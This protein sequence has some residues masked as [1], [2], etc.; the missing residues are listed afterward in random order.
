MYVKPVNE[1]TKDEVFTLGI[2]DTES[3]DIGGIKIFISKNHRFGTDALLL[4][5]FAAP[6]HK[7]NVCDLGTG[8]GIIPFLLF[9]DYK[10]KSITAVEIQPEAIGLLEH[11]VNAN[12]ILNITP[13]LADLRALPSDM[14]GH[15]DV[16]TCNPP[17]KA[18]G[19]GLTSET[20]AELIARHEVCCTLSDVCNASYK[21][22]KSGGRLC[23]INRS[24][25]LADVI[26]AMRSVRLEPKRLRFIAKDSKTPPVLF[27]I[28]G[29][30]DGKPFM[31]IEPQIFTHEM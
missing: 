6:R 21:L 20:P 14:N 7:D 11:S 2:S 4:S 28:E 5:R 16:I 17:Y 27:L 31:N 30:K 25:R 9:R 12:D 10:P 1:N 24:E 29:K 13:L 22:L 23:M 8:C 15:Y 3:E 26:A 19:T 18:A